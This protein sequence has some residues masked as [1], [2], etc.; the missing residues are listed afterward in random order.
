[1]GETEK[2]RHTSEDVRAEYSAVVSYHTA[3]VSTRFTI[4]GLY[5]A[6][7]GF[8]ASAVFNKDVTWVGRAAASGLACWLTLCLWMLELR[9]RALY[10]NLA[11]RGIDIE[12]NYWKLLGNDWYQGF[13]SRQYKEPPSTKEGNGTPQR[14]DPDQPTLGWSKQPLPKLLSRWI[15]HSMGLD[16][17]Y[18]GVGLFW[19]GTFILSVVALISRR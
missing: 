5:V 4:A 14:D 1:L 2:P 8:V 6:A 16:L 18:A 17:L 9:S 3:L 15:S 11:H 13:F 12:H 10:T 19:L 7:A